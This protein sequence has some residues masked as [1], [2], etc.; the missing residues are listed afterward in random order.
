MW[1]L[2]LRLSKQMVKTARDQSFEMET[3]QRTCCDF[4]TTLSNRG[5]LHQHDTP[6]QL[7]SK[8]KPGF[9][10]HIIAY[11]LPTVFILL[12]ALGVYLEKHLQKEAFIRERRLLERGV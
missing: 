10:I 3:L 12:N 1:R 11:T 9:L 8:W 6:R 2:N 5:S 4:T 7:A